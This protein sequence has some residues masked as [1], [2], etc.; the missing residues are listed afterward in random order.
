METSP[1]RTIHLIGITH[2]KN[3]PLT[4]AVKKMIATSYYF[5]GGVRHYELVKDLLPEQHHWI[6]IKGKMPDLISAYEAIEAP[7]LIFV[8]GDP[9]FYGFGNT[10]KRLA[11]QLKLAT[12]PA[13]NCLQLLCHHQQIAYNDLVAV[14]L[15]GRPWKKLDEALIKDL[16]LIGVLTDATHRPAAIAERLLYYNISNYSLLI[17]EEL[18]GPQA[19]VT[20]LSLS[21]AS[22]Y[23]AVDL[24]C[25]LLIKNNTKRRSFTQA[26]HQFRTL[27]GRPKMITKMPLR[28]LNIQLLALQQADTF[29]DIGSCTGAIALDA[30]HHYPHLNVLAIEKRSAC[31]AIIIENSQRQQIPEI[32]L[33]IDDFF[34]LD[35]GILPT[36]QSVFIGGHGGRL[37]ELIKTLDNYLQAGATVVM[38]TVLERSLTSFLTTYER[39]NYTLSKALKIDID[40][41]NTIH[42]LV[43]KKNT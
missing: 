8:S 37:E 34:N 7:I 5:S 24:N 15:H 14:S 36:P 23:K 19:K 11:P 30:K 38:N 18:G 28:L 2:Q 27:E 16:P 22:Q 26:D 25:V 21:E 9:F 3:P 20:T 1:N 33:L 42:V 35:L 17:G 29:W 40:N 13:F 32:Q 31:K 12:Y 6:S 43:A 39:M 41:N 4:E 10:L